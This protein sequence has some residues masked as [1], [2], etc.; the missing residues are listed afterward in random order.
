MVK[1]CQGHMSWTK[2]E[3]LLNN[4]CSVMRKKHK[5][6]MHPEEAKIQSSLRKMRDPELKHMCS[7][8]QR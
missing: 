2:F 3:Q 4:A 5:M 6:D 8:S 1:H 7:K